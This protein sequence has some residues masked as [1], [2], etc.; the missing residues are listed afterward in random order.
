MR[1]WS[2]MRAAERSRRGFTLLEVLAAVA[3]LGIA[4]TILG[5]AGIQGLQREGEAARRFEASLL[6]DRVL[7][8]IESAFDLGSAPPI[9]E[10]EQV[11]GDFLISIRVD[12]FDAVVP[13]RDR[14]RALERAEDRARRPGESRRDDRPGPGASLLVGAGG[15]PGP[16]RRVEIVVAWS[17]GWGERR[18]TRTTFGLDR[19][20][21]AEVISALGD[22]ARAAASAGAPG[23][24]GTGTPEA[25]P[26]G[27]P[28]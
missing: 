2:S 28:R 11:E 19:E 5:G 21:A 7:E 6:A 13:E 27:A 26:A 18:V 9:G 20:A 1:C 24:P 22:A 17:E 14:P 15:R 3:L 23:S 4:Y 10:D 12:P 8:G 25:A 16:L